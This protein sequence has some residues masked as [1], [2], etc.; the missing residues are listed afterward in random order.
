ML[1]LWLILHF[2]PPLLVLRTRSKKYQTTYFTRETCKTTL[3]HYLV[4]FFFVTVFT[5]SILFFID[6]LNV[7]LMRP[8]SI[9]PF[10]DAGFTF[11]YMLCA[12]VVASILGWLTGDM[13]ADLLAPFRQKS[14]PFL[15]CARLCVCPAMLISV[16]IFLF[17]PLD[18]YFANQYEF[19][20]SFPDIIGLFLGLTLISTLVLMGI[21]FL[22][23]AINQYIL[24]LFLALVFGLGFALYMQGNFMVVDYGLLDGTTIDW[25][26][27]ATWGEINRIIWTCLLVLPFLLLGLSKK[28]FSI[29]LTCLS[30]YVVGVQSLTLGVLFLSNDLSK[31]P[32]LS[33]TDLGQFELSQDHNVIIFLMDALDIAYTNEMLEL[34]PEIHTEFKDFTY[35][36]NVLSGY[37]YTRESLPLILTGI[38]YQNDVTYHDYREAAYPASEITQTISEMDYH[39]SYYVL[40]NYLTDT[41]ADLSENTMMLE[42]TLQDI[43]NFLAAYFELIG[44]RYA[45]HNQKYTWNTNYDFTPFQDLGDG[46]VAYSYQNIPFYNKLLTTQITAPHTG[47]LFKFYE[48]DGTHSP[49]DMNEFLE[50][51]RSQDTTYPLKARGCYRIVS[52]Y[53]D[54]LKE[55]GIY[56]CTTIVLMADHGQEQ[57]KQAPT[58]LIKPA[59]TTQ[60]TL[61]INSAPVGYHADWKDTF[62]ALLEGS[63][64]EEKGFFSIDADEPRIRQNYHFQ[65]SDVRSVFYTPDLYVLESDVHALDFTHEHWNGTIL[66][67]PNQGEY[68]I[69]WGEPCSLSGNIPLYEAAVKQGLFMRRYEPSWTYSTTEFIFYPE[70]STTKDLQLDLHYIDIKGDF[71]TVIL[72]VNGHAVGEEVITME[73]TVVSFVVPNQF[74]VEDVIEIKL[75]FPDAEKSN[76]ESRSVSVTELVCT[77]LNQ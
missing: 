11:L 37:G 33:N 77:E 61:A 69:T 60:D 6:P 41:V 31:E 19:W 25:A 46:Y 75:E 7:I 4:A 20:F 58:V 72:S 71:Q 43:P 18:F 27:Y 74:L 47:K 26:S 29:V 76:L 63:P 51:T 1:Y 48:L 22:C 38:S 12:M 15:Q 5:I 66:R 3:L 55:L 59:Y 32:Q 35:F 50:P 52:T 54:Q 42:P 34:F 68:P 28:W 10:T 49:L 8:F 17:G 36:D 14:L 21:S 57:L 65:P 40:P 16:T 73:D 23:N 39:A 24:Y 9:G 53:I 67:K 64:L 2:V 70:R 13:K 30:L 62:V 44:F 56:D 45:P